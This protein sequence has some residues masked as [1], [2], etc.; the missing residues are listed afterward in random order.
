MAHFKYK[1]ADATGKV[2]EGDLEAPN[3]ADVLSF[4]NREGLTPISVKPIAAPRVGFGLFRG[5][6]VTLEDKIFL[7]KY[8]ALMLKVGT[9]LFKAVDILIRDFEQPVLK[10][11]LFEVKTNL[12]KGSPFYVAFQNHPE[13]F[14]SVTVNLIKAAE[15]SGNLERTLND[16]SND[17]TK[18]ADLQNRIRGA[19]MYPILLIIG[20]GLVMT[21]LVTFV[22]PKIASI[23]SQSNFKIPFYSRIILGTGVFLG[24]YMKFIA[25]V[26]LAAAIAGWWYFTKVKRGREL[27]FEIIG[28]IPVVRDLLRRIALARFAS[29]L[30]SLLRA[31][32]PLIESL[33]ITSRAVGNE[34][35]RLALERIAKERIARGVS[36][37]DAFRSERVF[38]N[39]VTNLMSIGEKAGHLEEILTTLSD[40]YTS[41]ID[42]ALKSLV[43]F[44]EPVLLIGI[45]ALVAAIALSV[46]VPIYQLVSQY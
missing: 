33:E 11:F 6:G 43:S 41:E 4:L 35:F 16:L 17:F 5:K 7:T 31:G 28:R 44:I 37:G 20:A 22:I 40:F 25:P 36:I 3:E 46:I 32:I 14:S 34:D 19:L 27:L 23:F 15:E 42:S 2:R 39:V 8:L 12:E 1:A 38:P 45:G 10:E 24:T 21:L 13:F 29:T 30:S 18:Q 9:D 26:F